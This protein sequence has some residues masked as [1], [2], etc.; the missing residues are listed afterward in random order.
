MAVTWPATVPGYPAGR[1][2]S[3]GGRRWRSVRSS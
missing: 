1:A 2:E 3:A